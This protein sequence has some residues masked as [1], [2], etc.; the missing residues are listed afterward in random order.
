MCVLGGFDKFLDGV[1]GDGFHVDIDPVCPGMRARVLDHPLR[2]C[3]RCRE[4][5]V[6][7]VVGRNGV[8]QRGGDQR[9]D[10]GYG[11]TRVLLDGALT[12]GFD[13]IGPL[14]IG[15]VWFVAMLLAV[16]VVYRH[17][18]APHIVKPGSKPA[19]PG[20]G[21]DDAQDVAPSDLACGTFGSGSLARAVV[22]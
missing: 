15:L 9:V 17:S 16:A 1:A 10:P 2:I 12:R 21:R 20:T 5:G 7:G 6:F 11:G 3:A 8:P 22:P 4:D 13:E 19:G 14:L 18:I